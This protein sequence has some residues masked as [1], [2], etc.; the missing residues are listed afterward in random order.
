MEV[1]RKKRIGIIGFGQIREL[2]ASVRKNVMID[3]TVRENVPA[4]FRVTHPIY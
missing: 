2:V 1:T 4:Q 3:W